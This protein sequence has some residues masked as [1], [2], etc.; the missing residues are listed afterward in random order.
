MPQ[1]LKLKDRKILLDGE[2]HL[3]R[4]ISVSHIHIGLLHLIHAINIFGILV[5]LKYKIL[6][7]HNVT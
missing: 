4:E 5:H 3:T 2:N 1:K 7:S 6:K